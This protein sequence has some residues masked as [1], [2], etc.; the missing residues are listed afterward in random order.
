MCLLRLILSSTM[1]MSILSGLLLQDHAQHRFHI[2]SDS[3]ASGMSR[4]QF[5]I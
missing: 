3:A 4:T 2:I 1:I 5:L